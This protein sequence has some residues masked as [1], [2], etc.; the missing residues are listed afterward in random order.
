MQPTP[1]R[2]L[3]LFPVIFF[4]A[5]GAFAFSAIQHPGMDFRGYYGAALLVRRGGNPYDY[6][7]LAPLLEQVSGFL[8]NNPYFYPPWYCLFFLPLTFLTFR[9]AQILWIGI[10]LALFYTS[11]EWLWDALD[12]PVERWFRWPVFTFAA[13]LFGYNALTSENSGFVLLFGLAA[14]LRGLKRSDSPLAGFGFLLLLTKPQATIFAA[15]ALGLWML[16]H[17]P[18]AAAWSAGWV[19]GMLLVATLAIPRWWDFDRTGFGL[20]IS[21]YQEGAGQVVG[22]RV[23]ATLYDLLG[24]GFGLP[25]WIQALAA[26]GIGLAGAIL[27]TRTWRQGRDPLTLAAST[28]LLTLLVTPY[29]LYYDFVPLTLVFFLIARDLPALPRA[30]AIVIALLLLASIG[31]QLLARLQFHTYWIVLILTASFA[32]TQFLSRREPAS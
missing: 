15:L 12:W 27:V 13:I 16:R 3:M 7:Q 20:G 30:A 2:T 23:A 9:A 32:L 21:Y 29:A 19:A 22:K 8:G 17:R 25:F 14:L 26:A 4:L 31:I 10:N 24:Y 5:L 28:L 6:A 11:L 18:R 1:R